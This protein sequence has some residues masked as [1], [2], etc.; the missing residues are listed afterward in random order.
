MSADEQG[1]TWRTRRAKCAERLADYGEFFA[2]V[3]AASERGDKRAVV[4]LWKEADAGL[5]M[6]DDLFGALQSLAT[7]HKLAI[8][9]DRCGPVSMLLIIADA[10]LSEGRLQDAAAALDRADLAVDE[11]TP[12]SVRRT[13]EELE[14]RIG[15]GNRHGWMAIIEIAKKDGSLRLTARKVLEAL[16]APT[17]EKV[18]EECGLE[19]DTVRK[20]SEPLQR[21]KLMKQTD[22]GWE[23]GAEGADA[24]DR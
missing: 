20:K 10:L 13:L 14:Q 9:S 11:S 23:L 18:A 22:A 16:P 3:K 8:R 19:F 5:Y 17:L 2:D 15:D 21:G 7:D 24:L 6:G 1:E 12:R 4:E